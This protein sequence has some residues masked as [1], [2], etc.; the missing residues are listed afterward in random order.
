M[1]ISVEGVD[2]D[3]QCKK[4][5]IKK[6]FVLGFVLTLRIDIC[7]ICIVLSSVNERDEWGG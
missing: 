2:H 4:K 3:I 7:V 6:E 5:I 1:T